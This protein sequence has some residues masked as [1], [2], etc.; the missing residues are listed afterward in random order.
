MTDA[1]KVTVYARIRRCLLLA[2]SRYPSPDSSPETAARKFGWDRHR[3]S[4][5]GCAGFREQAH[6]ISDLDRSK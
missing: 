1:E 4:Q 3:S 5:D 6:R 2:F